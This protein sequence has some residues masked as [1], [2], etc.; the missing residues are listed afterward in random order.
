MK[1]TSAK[2]FPAAAI[3][4]TP[5]SPKTRVYLR[6]KGMQGWEGEKLGF[7]A[8]LALGDERQSPFCLFAANGSFIPACHEA[9]CDT[10]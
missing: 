5:L 8:A 10:L 4:Q 9:F 6:R 2:S 3:P 7:F 1:V